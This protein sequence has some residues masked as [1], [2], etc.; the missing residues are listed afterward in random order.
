MYVNTK[1]HG[2]L[3][4]AKE[5]LESVKETCGIEVLEQC[6]ECKGSDLINSTYQH[7]FVDRTGQVFHGIL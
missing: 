3:V 7:P 2:Y 6:G 1:D 5:R 4:I